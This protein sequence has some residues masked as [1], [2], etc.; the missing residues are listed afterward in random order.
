MCLSISSHIEK[1]NAAENP[2]LVALT[3]REKSQ[4]NKVGG[5]AA[6]K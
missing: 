2:E 1:S 6:K 4:T 3:L 5:F